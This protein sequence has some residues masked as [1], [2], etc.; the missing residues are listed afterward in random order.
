[1]KSWFLRTGLF[2]IGSALFGLLGVGLYGR[3]QLSFQGIALQLLLFSLGTIA[4][5]YL[6]TWPHLLAA[7][8]LFAWSGMIGY[9]LSPLVGF[10]HQILSATALS[11]VFATVATLATVYGSLLCR[12]QLTPEQ[13]DR[14]VSLGLW[15]LMAASLVGVGGF[16]FCDFF[17]IRS[18]RLML[19]GVVGIA[20]LLAIVYFILFAFFIVPRSDPSRSWLKEG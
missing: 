18:G 6:A 13:R 3:H 14:L 5:G 4:L 10:Y 12:P 17:N 8:G 1:M 7:G 15:G 19:E 11:I 2:M 16:F 20:L 9:D